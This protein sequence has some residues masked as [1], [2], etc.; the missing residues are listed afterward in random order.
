MDEAEIEAGGFKE[1]PVN[2]IARI[3]Y[4]NRNWQKC[5]YNQSAEK[6][7]FI[8]I[9]QWD[10]RDR[11]SFPIDFGY[12][13]SSQ[14]RTAKGEVINVELL[15]PTSIGQVEKLFRETFVK[16]QFQDYE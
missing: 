8:T 1:F 7:Y 6:A 9:E 4:V 5:Y 15:S 11:P 10:W 16:M 3:R 12:Q 13:A 2:Q 14:F